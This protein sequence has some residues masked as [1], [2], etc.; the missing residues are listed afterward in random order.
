MVI[1]PWAKPGFIDS[2]TLSYDAYLKLIEDRF[3]GG[4]AARPRD[5]RVARLAADGPRGGEAA[6]RSRPRLRL[7]ARSRCRRSCS[8]PGR[9]AA[10]TG[11]SID[12]PALFEPGTAGG[13]RSR[14]GPS[15]AAPPARLATR[16]DA[17]R[18]GLVAARVRVGGRR[19]RRPAPSAAP[20]SP[21]SGRDRARPEP[22]GEVPLPF[23]VPDR[24][25]VAPERAPI[26]VDARPLR[27]PP[28]LQP[29]ADPFRPFDPAAGIMNL[30]HL[31]FVV[32]E[33][34]SFDHY[35]GTFPGA[36]GIPMDDERRRR[37]SA[38]PIRRARAMLSPAVPRPQP[39]R[40][41]RAARGAVASQISIAGGRMNGFVR[42]F[43]HQGQ[44][45]REG[46]DGAAV[47]EDDARGP[48]ARARPT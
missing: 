34:R 2:Q 41:G 16:R 29:V 27:D 30:D 46:P 4:A 33:N 18:G 28:P 19:A 35:F 38:C 6:R 37:P 48:T 36:D 23:L 24:F 43:R 3:L 22:T 14:D 7:H 1:S 11:V 31:V 47:P 12:R 20:A 21:I 10:E 5:R 44:R 32:Q 26:G 9:S 8:I 17:D 13:L 39:V 15:R 42:A 40:L 45:L 25:P